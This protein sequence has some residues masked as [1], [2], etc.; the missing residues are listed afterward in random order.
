SADGFAGPD[1][2]Q[3]T[4][5]GPG[6]HDLIAA[7]LGHTCAVRRDG[8][9]RCWGAGTDGQ[10]GNGVLA[11]S[12]QLVT[13]A[14]LGN[15]TAVAAG[16]RTSMALRSDG[17]VWRWGTRW[18]QA[19]HPSDSTPQQVPNLTSVIAISAGQ[20]AACAVRSNGHVWCWG[21]G[22]LGDGVNTLSDVPVEVV[23]ITSAIDVDVGAQSNACALLANGTVK[24]WGDNQD[25]QLGDGT[26]NAAATPVAV[27]GVTQAVDIATD[28]NASCAVIAS[29]IVRCWGSNA[30]GMLGIGTLFPPES[31]SPVPVA[32]ISDAIE[33]DIGWTQHVCARRSNGTEVCWGRNDAGQIGN[34]DGGY[35]HSET[36]P[37]AVV[38]LDR[39]VAITNGGHACALRSDGTARCWGSNLHGE[40]GN[41]NTGDVDL[42]V[43][44][45]GLSATT[46]GPR[47]TTGSDHTCALGTD[48]TVKCWGDNA[49]GQLGNGNMIDQSTPTLVA[50]LSRV[51]S[52][53]ANGMH[54]CAVIDDG[55]VKCWGRNLAG[56]LGDGGASGIRSLTPVTVVGISD[57]VQVSASS[58]ANCVV[59][60][61]GTVSCWGSNVFG[62]LGN[63]TNVD[64]NVP[65][66][67]AGLT[68]AVAIN[69]RS[70]HV[71][72]LT[73]GSNVKCW[74]HNLYG[75][76]GNGNSGPGADT[77]TP[78]TVTLGGIFPVALSNVVAVAVGN[79]HSCAVI[80]DGTARCWGSGFNGALGNGAWNDQSHPVTVTGLS[81]A[82]D[83]SA[84]SSSSC[85]LRATGGARC[86]GSNAYGELGHG[87]GPM[88][89]T[90]SAVGLFPFYLSNAI[91]ID[92]GFDHSC[93]AKGDGTMACW[94]LNA[95]GQ[96]GDGTTTNRT[97][98]VTVVAFP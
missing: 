8:T 53:A 15:V 44:V 68:N 55:T 6:A 61:T 19:A 43:T 9:V 22:P 57:A 98:P 36:L 37:D 21:S 82:I 89:N 92:S 33:V 95:D 62:Q 54:T 18:G 17:T 51:T 75:Q 80:A 49:E 93:V 90:P 52:L 11:D 2:A 67:V 84:G 91:A 16:V 5:R 94:G 74:G 70:I 7:G 83:V 46:D 79:T 45:V 60:S 14:G 4:T 41:G 48:G 32:G 77:N 85:A 69:S 56:E 20:E 29:G 27:Q 28:A 50:G 26:T 30:G 65:V 38:G 34:G 31:L 59:R 35:G 76:L 24:C 40:V 39:V 96:V 3:H 78:V 42:P 72:A 66:A 97:L 25:G 10:L 12:L 73:A 23:G 1:E 63:G 64:S 88:T 87:A 81:D 58:Q 71:C 13:V 47:V 86:W